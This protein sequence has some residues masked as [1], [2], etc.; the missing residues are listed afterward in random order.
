M[1]EGWYVIGTY[2]LVPKKLQGVVRYELSATNTRAGGTTSESW[3][4]GTNYFIKGDDLKLAFNYT[5]GDPAGRDPRA[6]E[7]NAIIHSGVTGIGH[8]AKFTL[9]PNCQFAAQRRGFC[10]D[11][12]HVL[13]W[14]GLRRSGLNDF[15]CVQRTC[16]QGDASQAPCRDAGCA[17]K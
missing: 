15:Y 6:P 8:P 3:V 13:S 5:L 12:H 9:C 2:F 1:G 16:L 17:H 7:Q 10:Q 14:A 4:I 11:L